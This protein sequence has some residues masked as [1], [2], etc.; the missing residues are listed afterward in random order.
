VDSDAV[1]VYITITA[2]ALNPDLTIVA[3]AARP[4]S[5]S[6]LTRAGADR[7]VSPY[8]L[9]GKR[10]A[11]LS[12]RPAVVEFIDMVT[13][14]PNLRL[15]EVYVRPGSSLEGSRVGEAR[16]AHPGAIVLAVKKEGAELVPSPADE[17]TLD[18]GDLVVVMGAAE[19]LE[20]MARR[21]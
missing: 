6:T 11:F 9:S 19:A 2:R 4:E 17:T 5:A 21:R 15:E 13:L 3:R 10:M 18:P 20:S 1:N 7:V 16:A 8:A 14:A 12:T